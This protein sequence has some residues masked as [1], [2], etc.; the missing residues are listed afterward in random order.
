[1]LQS[2]AVDLYTFFSTFLIYKV[3]FV[4]VFL[5]PQR[6]FISENFSCELRA[7]NMLGRDARSEGVATLIPLEGWIRLE[8]S[9]GLM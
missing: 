8:R 5:T 4:K 9:P 3:T 1:M 6:T 2:I 7:M